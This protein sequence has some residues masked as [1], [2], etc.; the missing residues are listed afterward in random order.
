MD[1]SEDLYHQL[2]RK[3]AAACIS[4]K[5]G[6]KSIDYTLKTYVKEGGNIDEAWIELAKQAYEIMK[7]RP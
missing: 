4:Q 5:L 7:R 2:A 1:S 6:N 3:L